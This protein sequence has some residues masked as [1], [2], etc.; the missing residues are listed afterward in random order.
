MRINQEILSTTKA[1]EGLSARPPKSAL[2]PAPLRNK[3][4]VEF[5]DPENK[6]D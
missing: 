1:N 6:G 5:G 3:R 4:S 2:L